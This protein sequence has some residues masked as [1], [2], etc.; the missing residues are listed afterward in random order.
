MKRTDFLSLLLGMPL[1]AQQKK[2]TRDLRIKPVTTN[3]R[4]LQLGQTDAAAQIP[5]ASSGR[6]RALCI[7]NNAYRYV[8]PLRNAVNDA[9]DMSAALKGSRF[10]TFVV[11]DGSL[12]QTQEA[13]RR[14]I[15]TTNVGDTAFFFFAGHGFQLE[16]GNFLVP[17]DFQAKDEQTALQTTL[18]A[19]SITQALVRKKANRTV[20]LLDACRN[21]PFQENAPAGLAPVPPLLGSMAMFATGAGRT[22][23]DNPNG[24]NGLFTSKLLAGFNAR[25]SLQSVARKVRDEVFE[26]SAGRQRPYVQ[27]D[28]VGEFSL[29]QQA[30][31]QTAG[32]PKALD[33]LLQEGMA[34][35]RAG[36]FAAAFAAFDK[37]TKIDQENVQAWNA[38]G[39]AL[40]QLGRQAQA[41]EL[42]GRAI[43]ANPAY[44]AA[45]VNRGLAY[46]SVPQYPAAIQDFSWAL[47]E[48]NANPLLYQWRGQAYLG[49]RNYE[50]GLED[51]DRAVELDPGAPESHR[52]RGRIRHRLAKFQ[53]ALED[54]NMALR[55]RRD[56]WQALQDRAA[57][58]RA[59]GQTQ[60][61]AADE[62][63]AAA[64]SK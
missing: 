53:D 7:G 13:I 44:V 42:Y 59:M 30:E 6:R 41:V 47:E 35:Y 37:A 5:G 49:S 20:L 15:D 17:T 3:K 54:Y 16:G 10:E 32:A 12:S 18:R 63:A 4:D 50:A 43:Q 2:D 34:H 52:L 11:T 33:T 24:K 55:I 60:K 14:F 57:T 31:V 23:D 28:L 9:V 25:E 29:Q 22:A 39:S 19:E 36:D 1:V 8:R 58:Y 21:N 56:F 61:A 64:L 27:E 46:L 38:A 51:L 48:D 62:K 26:A 40:A 45:H